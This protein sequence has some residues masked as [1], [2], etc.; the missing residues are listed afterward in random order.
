[1]NELMK[2]I[3]FNKFQMKKAVDE[4][5]ATATDLADW[6]VQN[7]DYSFRDAYRLTGKIVNFSYKKNKI[8]ENLTLGEF[9]KFDKNISK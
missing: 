3:K 2:K 7:L 1:M 9:K 5:N 6:L 8:L 4:S